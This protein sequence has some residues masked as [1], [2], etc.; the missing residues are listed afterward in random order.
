M[1]KPCGDWKFIGITFPDNRHVI[2]AKSWIA[3]SLFIR[4]DESRWDE[5]CYTLL[6]WPFDG[7]SP[8][9]LGALLFSRHDRKKRMGNPP[10]REGA[11]PGLDR[12]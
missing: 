9:P 1:V 7:P 4:V 3:S 2:A 6:N 12:H 5:F 11:N 8:T 10:D